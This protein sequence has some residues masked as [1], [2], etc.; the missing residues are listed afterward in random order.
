MDFDWLLSAMPYGDRWRLG[1]KLLHAQANV[2]AAVDYGPIQLQGARRFVRDLL[3]A[4]TSRPADKVSDAAN[5]VLP[6]MIRTNVGT[7]AVRMI[8]GINVRDPVAEAKYVDVPETIIST[9]GEAGK[10]GRFLV[11]LFPL[12]K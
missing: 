11:D 10:P 2:G 3:S 1:R 6:R 8:Y 4:E 7:T 12:R 9:I 5:A